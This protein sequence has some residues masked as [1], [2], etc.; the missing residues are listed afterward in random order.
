MLYLTYL[1][2]YSPGRIEHEEDGERRPAEG[3]KA[4]GEPSGTNGKGPGD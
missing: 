4:S 3:Q 2:G 1:G